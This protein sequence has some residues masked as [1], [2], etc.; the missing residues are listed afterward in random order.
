MLFSLCVLIYIIFAHYLKFIVE[1]K[2][3]ID[4]FSKTV[5]GSSFRQFFG[6]NFEVFFLF[7]KDCRF[8]Q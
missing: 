6:L 3:A 5:S 2:T 7:L 8:S 1:S 4:V